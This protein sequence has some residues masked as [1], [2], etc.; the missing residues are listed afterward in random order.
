LK[1]ARAAIAGCKLLQRPHGAAFIAAER[2]ASIARTRID[3]DRV[4]RELARIAFTDIA[5]IVEW[6][7]EGTLALKPSATISPDDGAAIAQ[8]KLKPGAR[9]VKATVTL[10]SKQRAL[11]SLARMMG[12]HGKKPFVTIDHEQ[13]ARRMPSCASGCCASCA[14]AGTGGAVGEWKLRRRVSLLH[15]PFASE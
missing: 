15:K 8:L 11:D 5:D 3:V 2:A 7:E 13:G 1:V 6:D 9:G 14:A 10:H 12:L 4:K